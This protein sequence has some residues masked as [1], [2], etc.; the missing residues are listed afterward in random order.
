L[1]IESKINSMI[2]DEIASVAKRGS[3][4]VGEVSMS[5]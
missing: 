3:V 1:T 4:A 2:R 5:T